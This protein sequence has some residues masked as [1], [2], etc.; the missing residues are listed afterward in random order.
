MGVG[1]AQNER[2]WRRLVSASDPVESALKL[3]KLN[4]DPIHP[5]EADEAER[6]KL[7]SLC[8][9]VAVRE[10]VRRARGYA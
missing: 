8:E 7:G 1:L 6:A 9:E 5:F 2:R 4:T 10:Q 3:F